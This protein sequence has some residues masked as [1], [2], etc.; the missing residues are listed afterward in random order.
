MN[1]FITLLNCK[2]R[3]AVLCFINMKVSDKTD[4]ANFTYPYFNITDRT[5]QCFGSDSLP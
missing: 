1:Q 5:L 3:T 2:V 4:K